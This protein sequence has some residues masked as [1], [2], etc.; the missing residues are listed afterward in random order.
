MIQ[1][2]YRIGVLHIHKWKWIIFD[3][4]LP[5][6]PGAEIPNVDGCNKLDYIAFVIE[7]EA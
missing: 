5:V 4:K 2:I 7:K 3:S 6:S 1:P